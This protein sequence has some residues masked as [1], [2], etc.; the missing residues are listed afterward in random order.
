MTAAPGTA[1]APEPNDTARR[2]DQLVPVGADG[3]QQD[4][5]DVTVLDYL[6]SE[7]GHQTVTQ[8]VGMLVEIQK[9]AHEAQKLAQ[10]ATAELDKQKL[11][12]QKKSWT[13][14]MWVQIAVFAIAISVAASL[15]WHGK[16]DGGMGTLIGTL[17]GYALGRNRQT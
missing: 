11:E 9:A 15:A 2:D 10:Q 6:M 7:K 12:L 17:V 5:Y 4:D 14:W 8:V 3:V 16:L 1:P 13:A